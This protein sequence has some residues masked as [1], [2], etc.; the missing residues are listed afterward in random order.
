MNKAVRLLGTIGLGAGAMYFLDPRRGNRRRALVRDK[1]TSLLARSDGAIDKTARDLQNRMRGTMVEI[2][3][4]LS[5][6]EASN[7]VVEERVRAEIGRISRYSSSIDVNVQQGSVTLSGPILKDEVDR[8]LSAVSRVKGVDRVENHLD[9]H[10]SADNIPGLQGTPQ[11]REPKFELM[12]ENWS[13]T[14]RLVTGLGG[15]ALLLYGMTRRGIIGTTVGLAG[16]GLAARGVTNIELKRIIGVGGGRRAIDIQKT[17]NVNAPVDEVYSFWKNYE[18]FP[19]FMDH[20][21]EVRAIDDGRSHWVVSAPAGTTV[22]WNAVTTKDIPNEVIAW[23]SEPDATVK[24]AGIVQ[25][26]PNPD[27]STR[28][29]VRMS[30]NPPAGAIGHAIA[31]LFGADPKQAM[32]EDMVRLKSLLEHGKTTAHGKE[33]K[34]QEIGGATGP[35]A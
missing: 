14:A 9:V 31:S 6:D 17:I 7:W 8:V 1:M 16:L 2:M 5:G 23:K 10:E 3:D 26:E 28:I 12:Q 30:Y 29:T 27:G 13:P 33:V 11:R 25:F 22:E 20:V 15:G 19:R 24:S 32:D 4:L 21:H 18:N 35:A 34:K